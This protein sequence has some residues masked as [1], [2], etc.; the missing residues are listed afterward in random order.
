MGRGTS[1]TA[2]SVAIVRGSSVVVGWRMVPVR[3]VAAGRGVAAAV[4]VVCWWRRVARAFTG[5][6]A[7]ANLAF[8]SATSLDGKYCG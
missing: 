5:V 6:G 8:A 2:A 3:R 1:A 7:F 4:V